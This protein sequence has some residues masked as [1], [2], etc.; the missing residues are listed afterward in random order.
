VTSQENENTKILSVLMPVYNEAPRI[1]EVLDLVRAVPLKME[2]V[3]VDDCST[4][5]TTEIL[6][7]EAANDP[8][9][10]LIR[11]EI[12]KGKGAAVRTARG[13]ATGQVV[14][15]Q[16]GDSEYDPQ[17]YPKLIAPIFDGSVRAV[18][19]SRF[20]GNNENMHVLNLIANKFLT[21]QTNVLYGTGITDA[22]TAY[23]ALDAEWFKSVEL[24]AD[25][26]EFCHELAVKLYDDEI[27][28][29]EVP[30]SYYAR[31]SSEGKKVGWEQLF[32]ST[33]LLTRMK[34]V[35][36]FGRRHGSGR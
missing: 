8:S 18:F 5:G 21:W 17:D 29:T 31:R 2:I 32:I 10:K 24:D 33:W 3:V 9:I 35:R 1:K 12:N 15:I 25:G 34:F 19:G 27:D 11:H 13:H 6:E 7:E 30:I 26:F 28:V 4:D 22:C 16:D 23:K 36:M 14:I 20:Q